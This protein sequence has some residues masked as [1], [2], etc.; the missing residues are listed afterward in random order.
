MEK[1]NGLD[2]LALEAGIQ[3]GFHDHR[4]VF[5]P[6]SDDTKTTLLQ[7]MG[8]M[9]QGTD[10]ETVLAELRLRRRQSLLPQ[11]LVLSEEDPVHTIPLMLDLEEIGGELSYYLAADQGESFS[12][13][14]SEEN[15]QP[16]EPEKTGEGRQQRVFF[17]LKRKLLPGYHRLILHSAKREATLRL[18][19]APMSCYLPEQLCDKHRLWGLSLNL[20]SLSSSSNWGIGDFSDLEKFIDLAAQTGGD[21]IGLSLLHVHGRTCSFSPS[22]RYFADPLLCD[23]TRITDYDA[24]SF[25]DS[26]FAS[27]MSACRQAESG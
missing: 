20:S 8:L 3:P 16:V 26:R 19:I 23:L 24:E 12:G 11:V 7:E 10:P 2:L 22:T 13:H 5:Q 21:A 27:L 17:Q 18:I 15:L 6:I 14:V 25:Q 1:Q 9:P 4:N